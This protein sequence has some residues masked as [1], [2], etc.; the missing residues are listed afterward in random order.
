MS[1]KEAMKDVLSSDKTKKLDDDRRVS[2]VKMVQDLAGNL[3]NSTILLG[4]KSSGQAQ[5]ADAVAVAQQQLEQV[6]L[7]KEQEERQRREMQEAA[8]RLAAMADTE[9]NRRKRKR[10]KIIIGVICGFLGVVLVSVG[11]IVVMRLVNPPAE[12]PGGLDLSGS[13][14]SNLPEDNGPIVAVDVASA[15]VQG[16]YGKFSFTGLCSHLGQTQDFYRNEAVLSGAPSNQM[17]IDIALGTMGAETQC[18]VNRENEP[19]LR[20]RYEKYRS[21]DRRK[22]ELWEMQMWWDEGCFDGLML[23]PRT[24]EI[25][26][27]TATITDDIVSNPH[28]H[29][30]D[31]YDEI[32]HYGN[33]VSCAGFDFVRVPVRAEQDDKYLYVYEMVGETDGTR[34]FG[35]Y[36]TPT[37]VNGEGAGFDY[38]GGTMQEYMLA[39]P[40]QF[41]MFRWKF[42]KEGGSYRFAGLTE[43]ESAV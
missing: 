28:L 8:R 14:V 35:L 39:H 9:E 42:L 6:R 17:M 29:Y 10:K 7:A 13:L 25:F 24:E 1:F 11:V 20:N 23:K 22:L 37:T 32:F 30:S 34:L 26:G 3:A 4:Q 16:S 21:S 33:R 31:T 36:E 41:K 19:A 15:E 27:W 5:D 43:V 38:S 2:G 12:E 40:G 18:K